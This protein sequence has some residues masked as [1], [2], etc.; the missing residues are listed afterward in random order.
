MVDYT[1]NPPC[2]S[3]GTTFWSPTV[4]APP[5]VT[6][7]PPCPQKGFDQV[8][9][10]ATVTFLPLYHVLP[11]CPQKGFDQ[12]EPSATIIFLPLYHVL[13]PTF[14]VSITY[15]LVRSFQITEPDEVLKNEVR[16]TNPRKPAAS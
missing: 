10:S 4:T 14:L 7:N 11:P 15:P 12:I 16:R 6:V 13:P 3:R 8:S 9:P 2:P 5:N 1:I